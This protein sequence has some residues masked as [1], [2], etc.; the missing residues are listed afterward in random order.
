MTRVRQYN[1][2][3][4]RWETHEFETRTAAI[5]YVASHRII[6]WSAKYIYILED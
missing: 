1:E 5:H 3:K 4:D 6:G 2:L